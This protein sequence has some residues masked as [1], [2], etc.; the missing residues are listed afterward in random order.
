ML[1]YIIVGALILASVV[2]IGV[3]TLVYNIGIDSYSDKID[4]MT[5]LYEKPWGRLAPYFMGALFGFTYFELSMK[6]KFP[7]L[8]GSFANKLYNFLQDS[9]LLSIFVATFGIGLTA[10][11]VFPNQ[12]YYQN[13][14]IGGDDPTKKCWGKGVIF[15]YNATSK[16][17][18]TLGLGLILMPTYVGRLRVIKSFLSTDFFVVMG[19]LNYTVYMIHCVILFMFLASQKQ[20]SY[21]TSVSQWFISVATFMIS[22]MFAVP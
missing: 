20:G 9:R 17:L 21:V 11:I 3:L 1:G 15:L 12:N 7:E 10:L 8:A 2:T 5:W 16:A 18:F 14:A 6:E 13:C 4:G 22:F 19:R